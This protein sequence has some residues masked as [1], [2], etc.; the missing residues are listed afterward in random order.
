MEIFKIA[1]LGIAAVAI[2]VFVK[3]WK[4]ELAMQ[5]SLSAAIVILITVLPYLKTAIN[6]L[7]DI[8]EQT[9]LDNSQIGLVLKVVGIAYI[10]QFASELCRDAGENAVATKIELAGKIII[11]TLS[12]PVIYR[13]MGIVNDIISFDL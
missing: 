7:K 4:P 1:G 10:A 2:A 13:L 9:G 12:M 8:S 5:I 3:N 6:M 11:M